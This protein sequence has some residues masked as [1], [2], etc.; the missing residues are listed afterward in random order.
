MVEALR[1]A[2]KARPDKVCAVML[3]TKGPEIR[4]GMLKDGQPVEFQTDQ[5]IEILTDY[6]LEGDETRLTCSYQAL[7]TTVKPGDI[8][9]VADGVLHC[10]VLECFENSVRVRCKNNAKIGERKNMN[11]PGCTVDLPSITEKDE[12]DMVEFGIKQGVDIIAP[13]FIR[14]PE[15]ITKIREVLGAR[16]AH[17][18]IISKIENQEV[19]KNFDAILEA[20]D[21]I[22]VARGDLGMEIPP[23]K[24]FLAQK[25]MINKCNFAAKP[26]ITATQML[27]SMISKPR[28]TRAEATDVANAVLDGSDCVMLSGESASGE[29]PIN[30][31]SML[32]KI[33]TEAEK[34]INYQTLYDHMKQ[35]S[36]K[37]VLT[38]ESVAAS[39]AS[40]ALTLG[41]DL[42]IVLTDT[43]RIARQVAKYRPKQPIFACSVSSSTVKQL[44]MTRG[45]IGLVIGSFQGSDNI[46]KNVIQ[47]AKEQGLCESGNKI[48]A[49]HST[50]EENP[51]QSD[52]MEI[53]TVE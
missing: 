47:T 28:P 42:I 13:S 34:N 37:P 4:T 30:S 10:E 6:S 5:E 24:V 23:E 44:Q 11:L 18:K 2:L 53:L 43:G 12:N 49:L 8:I 29:Y 9:L 17:I 35:N 1:N 33:S 52:I 50:N 40:A 45:I 16:G 21:G 51:D 39:A 31:V 48:I 19:L 36:D 26:V 15:D 22:M 3:D 38:S 7:P 14:K 27:D 25:W 20:C 41:I 46:I 32:A